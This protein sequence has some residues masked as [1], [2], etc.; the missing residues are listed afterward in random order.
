MVDSTSDELFA[1]S[2]FPENKDGSI[3][4]RDVLLLLCAASLTVWNLFGKVHTRV[5]GHAGCCD[6]IAARGPSGRAGCLPIRR[7]DVVALL[8]L[9]TL[10]RGNRLSPDSALF[11]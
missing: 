11:E 2:C 6:D 10:T 4:S 5:R 9:Q 8:N 7:S 3:R 1:C